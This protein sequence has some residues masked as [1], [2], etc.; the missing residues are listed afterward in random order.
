[1]Q[2]SQCVSLYLQQNGCTV[3]TDAANVNVARFR[4]AR[5]AVGYICVEK[6]AGKCITRLN[7]SDS[8]S[9]SYLT[10]LKHHQLD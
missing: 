4:V 5:E 1:M 6:A 8:M 10:Y 3:P 2:V 9:G 7:M